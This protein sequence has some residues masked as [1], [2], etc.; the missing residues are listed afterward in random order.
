MRRFA[1]T[2][3]LRILLALD[4]L[5]FAVFFFLPQVQ[6]VD[7]PVLRSAL[8]LDGYGAWIAASNPLVVNLAIGLRVVFS[9][10]LFFGLPWGKHVLVLSMLFTCAA[11]AI[12]GLAVLTS[13]DLLTLTV[14]YFLDGCLLVRSFSEAR[15]GAA[16][17]RPRVKS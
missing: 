9:G 12:G 2:T 5:A 10:L 8:E 17:S 1:P 16:G 6:A 13:L 7:S 15:A 3:A 11:T 4:L 14:L